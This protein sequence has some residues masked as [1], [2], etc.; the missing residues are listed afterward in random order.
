MTARP[1][2]RCRWTAARPDALDSVNSTGGDWGQDG[3]IY[4][5][6][7]S[8]IARIRASGGPIEPVYNFSSRRS[9]RSGAE[10]PVVLPGAA[11]SSSGLRSPNQPTSDFEIVAMPLPRGEPRV[12]MRGV[13]ARYSPTGHLLVV[14]ADGKLLAVPFDI[15]KLEITGPPVG[16]LEGIGVEAGAFATNLGLSDNG[17]LVYTTGGATRT[18]RPVWVGRDGVESLVDSAWQPQGI[19]NAFALAPDA[20]ALAWTSRRPATKP[21]G[22]SSS[23]PARCPG[24]PSATPRTCAPRGPP[25]DA[26]WSTSATRTRTAERR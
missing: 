2:G 3:Y 5:E 7:D 13:Y 1:F 14:G 22:S 10:W 24:S 15:D 16:L 8:G 11:G 17:T 6:V 18:R 21:S 26:R 12:L 9:A 25:T 19:V 20:H 4:F 23:R